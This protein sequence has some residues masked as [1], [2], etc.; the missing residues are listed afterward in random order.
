MLIIDISYLV[1]QL[2]IDYQRSQCQGSDYLT[3]KNIGGIVVYSL[4]FTRVSSP[5]PFESIL[6]AITGT[7]IVLNVII[8]MYY[9]FN[10]QK[11][12][13]IFSFSSK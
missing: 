12:K 6:Y 7:D 13:E 10:T 11:T 9:I 2:S 4:L 1:S 3:K 5:P 8:S